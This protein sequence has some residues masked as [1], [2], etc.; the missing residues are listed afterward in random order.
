MESFRE[1]REALMTAY[2]QNAII[3]LYNVNSSKNLSFPYQNY[4]KF[5]LDSMTDAECFTEL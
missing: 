1:T 3:D 4:E 2:S 5:D